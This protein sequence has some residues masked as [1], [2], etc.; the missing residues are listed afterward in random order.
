MSRF[1]DGKCLDCGNPVFNPKAHKKW[2]LNHCCCTDPKFDHLL[3]VLFSYQVQILID[4]M[5]PPS[6]NSNSLQIIYEV[7]KNQ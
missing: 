1:K 5:I 7:K 2:T 6:I 3:E 4:S